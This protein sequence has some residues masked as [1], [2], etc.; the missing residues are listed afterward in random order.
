MRLASSFR[1]SGG[2]TPLVL[3]GGPWSFFFSSTT[4]DTGTEQYDGH[5]GEIQKA[6]PIN[7]FAPSRQ[8]ELLLKRGFSMLAC[9]VCV[10]C[11]VCFAQIECI[12]EPLRA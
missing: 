1:A 9:C 7:L 5:P 11:Q 6:F 4:L 8:Y 12:V 10:V 3:S 2:T